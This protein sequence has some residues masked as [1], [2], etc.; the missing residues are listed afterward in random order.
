MTKGFVSFLIAGCSMT[1]S[2]QYLPPTSGDQINLS[3]SIVDPYGGLGN[4]HPKS[5]VQP[6]YV[7]L[8]DHTY[9]YGR[10]TAGTRSPSRTTTASSSIRPMSPQACSSPPCHRPSRAATRCSCPTTRT[11]SQEHW[12][13]SIVKSFSFSP[14]VES[15][16]ICVTKTGYIPYILHVRNTE[17]IQNETYDEETMIMGNNIRIGSNVTSFREEGPVVVESGKTSISYSSE[18]FY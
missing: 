10:S 7:T 17:F 18:V 6:P 12:I 13:F 16:S 14:T 11:C 2:A 1:A 4:G 8:D 9:I 15:Y 5:P 3:V